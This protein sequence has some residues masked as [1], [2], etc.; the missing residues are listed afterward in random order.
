MIKL[1]AL[2]DRANWVRLAICETV[3]V[4]IIPALLDTDRAE[5]F[6]VRLLMIP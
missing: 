6:G 3:R 1:L 2:P 4:M 5:E